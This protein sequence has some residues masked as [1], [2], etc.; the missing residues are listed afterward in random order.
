MPLVTLKQRQKEYSTIF[1][2]WLIIYRVPCFRL[3]YGT[4]FDWGWLT[5]ICIMVMTDRMINCWYLRR[6]LRK[7]WWFNLTTKMYLII[8]FWKPKSINRFLDNDNSYKHYHNNKIICSCLCSGPD[9]IFNPTLF[10]LT[11]A[12]KL[13]SLRIHLKV[14]LDIKQDAFSMSNIELSRT[15]LKCHHKRNSFLNVTSA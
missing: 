12:L 6:I 14:G 5:A 11:Y 10:R 7:R 4:T 1:D 15:A 3:Q 8:E 2:I 9:T 13:N